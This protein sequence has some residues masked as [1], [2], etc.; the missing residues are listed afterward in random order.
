MPLRRRVVCAPGDGPKPQ[1]D[2]RARTCWRPLAGVCPQG[3]ASHGG[4]AVGRI[5]V[6]LRGGGGGPG[7]G[8]SVRRSALLTAQELGALHTRVLR[9][10]PVI[11]G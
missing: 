8:R 7:G 6:P 5:N 1:H 2:P 9:A 11:A 4:T 10:N 3:P